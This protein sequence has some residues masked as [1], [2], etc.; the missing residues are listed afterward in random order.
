MFGNKA[1][2]R[3]NSVLSDKNESLR[4]KIKA[5]QQAFGISNAQRVKLQKE[6]EALKENYADASKDIVELK[7]KVRLQNEADL[8]FA[9]IKII[10]EL[11]KG[12]KED[13]ITLSIEEQRR[14]AQQQMMYQNARQ[15]Q[16]YDFLKTVIGR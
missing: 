14:Y 16:F 11:I 6:L 8:M 4:E 9:S 5:W 15:S 3:E 12:K 10:A 7:E 13:K 2:K 1:L